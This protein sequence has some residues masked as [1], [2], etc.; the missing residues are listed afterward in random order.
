[1]GALALPGGALDVAAT[2]AATGGGACPRAPNSKLNTQN[3][4]LLF[5]AAGSA[6]LH[7]VDVTNPAA[8]V[9]TATLALSG[10]AQALAQNGAYLYVAAGTG[11]L[12]V[13]DVT[14]PTVPVEVGALALPGGALDVV[15]APATPGA[16]SPRLHVQNPFGLTPSYQPTGPCTY[17]ARLIAVRDA[18]PIYAFVAAGP[19]GLRVVDVTNPAAPFEVGS[20]AL[21]GSAH[22]VAANGAQVVLAT[23]LNGVVFVDA[24]DPA[25]PLPVD[26]DNTSGDSTRVRWDGPDV[27]VADDFGGLLVLHPGLAPRTWLPIVGR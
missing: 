19:G 26:A 7:V 23:G 18:T 3:S 22:G 16:I 6:G 27:F 5:V 17:S 20:L 12:R 2:T 14:T 24:S 9:L 1:V 8:P 11:G 25:N 4:Q 13:V 15:V 10:T 21:P